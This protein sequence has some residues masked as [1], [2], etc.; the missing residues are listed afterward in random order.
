MFKP[1]FNILAHYT[2]KHIITIKIHKTSTDIY[3]HIMMT[4]KFILKYN[5]KHNLNPLRLQKNIFFFAFC[6]SNSQDLGINPK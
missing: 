6:N 3:Q 2:S 5:K 1:F 4:D